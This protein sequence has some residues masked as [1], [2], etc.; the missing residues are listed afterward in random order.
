ML[1]GSKVVVVGVV[2][3]VVVVVVGVVVVVVVVGGVKSK[4]Q[5]TTINTIGIYYFQTAMLKTKS[6][7]IVVKPPLQFL[8]QKD[9]F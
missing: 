2:V 6:T 9:F 7:L 4:H 3:G 5:N 1:L 8:V